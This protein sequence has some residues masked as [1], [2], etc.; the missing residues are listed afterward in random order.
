MNALSFIACATCVN[1]SGQEDVVAANGAVFVMIGAL[2]I[3][4]LGIMGVLYSFVRRARRL[5][6]PV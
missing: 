4:F 2:G 6:P 1:Q 3:V 5:Q